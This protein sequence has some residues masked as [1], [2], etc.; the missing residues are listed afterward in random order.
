MR[1]QVSLNY[2]WEF[3]PEFNELYINNK[4]IKGTKQVMIP[5]TMKELPL[6]YFNDE[7]YQFIGTYSK[8]ISIDKELLDNNLF[9]NFQGVMNVSKIYLNGELL[10]IHEGGYT[11][12]EVDITKKV[13]EGDNLL[14]VIVDGSE[15]KNVPPFGHLI[16]YLTYSGIYREVSLKVL[17]KTFIEM[18]HVSTGEA[19]GLHEDEMII[20][21]ELKLNQLGKSE[22]VVKS[23]FY[24][25]GKL[26][27]ESVF[28][29]KIIDQESFT[30]PIKHIKR[31]D[32]DNPN[33]YDLIIEIIDG[34]TVI[35]TIKTRFGFRTVKFMPEGFF[36]NNKPVKLIGLN[37]HQS[38]PYV[39][40]AMP[41]R[42]Q[43]SDAIILKEFGCNIVRTSHYMQD[44]HFLN[45][46]DELG[47]LVLEETP[48]WQYIG[49]NHFKALTYQNIETMINTHYNHP[50]IITW[51]VRINESLD[52]HEFYEK[53]NDIARN[54]D[55]TRQTCGVR[56]TKKGD[57]L[58]DIYSYNDFSHIGNNPGLE[59]VKNITRGYVPYIVTEH[60]G[61]VF[62]TK[63]TDSEVRR[64]E[65]ALRH[66]NVID[67]AYS[68]KRISG[69]IG[70]CLADYNTHMQFGSN[71]RI[72]HHGVMDMFRIPK[73]A[74]YAYKTQKTT[75]PVLF[76]ASNM[77]PGDFKEFQL[78]ETVVFTNCDSVKVYKNDE[79]IDE[80]YSEWK[81]YPDIPN[82]PFIIDDLIGDL[83]INNE[84][85]KPRD[86]R[87]I[88]DLLLSFNRNGFNLPLKDKLKYLSLRSRKIIND[89]IIFELNEKY[90]AMQHAKPVIFKFEGY[91]EGE[92]VITKRRG[93]TKETH[94][95]AIADNSELEHGFTYDAT[96]VV[97]NMRDEFENDLLYSNETIN[98]KTSD[99]LELIG[100][101]NLPLIAGSIGFYVK[102][103]GKIGKA[104]IKI[105]SNR[106][107]ELKLDLTIKKGILEL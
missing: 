82:A 35:D 19:S 92:L 99:H 50:S 43:E 77:I 29:N 20:D 84:D 37:R 26:A 16:D 25:E 55:P 12:F 5:H 89:K 36:L 64:I 49:D 67:S 56:N 7:D 10:L 100:P 32:I 69:A 52:D 93:Q 23:S 105:G 24:F 96:R 44:E 103:T 2:D 1:K 58:E 51:G 31:W 74:A 90:L 80:Y 11:P 45:K 30:A 81:T 76:I 46:C 13:V 47:L 57:F 91:I 33:L 39:G 88:T 6:N 9:I 86:A 60:N 63:K 28:E 95:V 53:T 66:T 40:Y 34:E 75:E 71:D 15:I 21:I 8:S 79:F 83:I 73:Y 61:H 101:S 18:I 4:E 94:L 54:L 59:R 27:F 65:Q 106:H 42:I 104:T 17:P 70:W 85:F 97:V 48:G 62:P 41:K 102:T 98:I 3:I 22:Y 38:F 87:K 78:P 14:Q 72:C 68:S 107:K